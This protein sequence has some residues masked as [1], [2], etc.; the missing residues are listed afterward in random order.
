MLG[1]LN[2]LRSSVPSASGGLVSGGGYLIQFETPAKHNVLRIITV[3]ATIY[4]VPN[5]G[6][7]ASHANAKSTYK[8]KEL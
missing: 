5:V 2:V 4:I 6:T 1:H 3:L 8:P 7:R